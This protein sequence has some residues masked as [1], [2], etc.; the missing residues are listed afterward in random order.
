MPSHRHNYEVESTRG[1]L[2][3][4]T[5]LATLPVPY[6]MVTTPSWL[7]CRGCLIVIGEQDHLH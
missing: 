4:N 3:A 5:P 2:P 1:R 7:E 6:A